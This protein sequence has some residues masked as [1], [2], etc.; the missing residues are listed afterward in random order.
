MAVRRY[1]S[2][3]K[4]TGKHSLYFDVDSGVY[5][6]LGKVLGMPLLEGTGIDPTLP[7]IILSNGY[8]GRSFEEVECDVNQERF[9]GLVLALRRI[10]RAMGRVSYRHNLPSEKGDSQEHWGWRKLEDKKKGVMFNL[11]DCLGAV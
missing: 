5:L 9:T 1:D 10:E 2:D 3:S 7:D 8:G 11:A 4:S 6:I